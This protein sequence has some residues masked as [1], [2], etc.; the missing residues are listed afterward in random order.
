VAF[1]P[2]GRQ[3]ATGGDD[4]VTRLWQVATSR[5]RVALR[6]HQG[7]VAAVAFA[8]SGRLLLTAG[9]DG[10]ARL[11]N[12]GPL[13]HAL[14]PAV[15]R[16]T[17]SR[18]LDFRPGG[19]VLRSVE[20]IPGLIREWDLAMGLE[21]RVV[22]IGECTQVAFS[23]DGET[24]AAT[25]K[26]G[27][28]RLHRMEDGRETAVLHGHRGTVHDAA[29]RGDGRRLVTVGQDAT[30]RLWDVPSGRERAVLRGHVGE[31][32]A[33][34]FRPDGRVVATGG[35]DGTLRFWDAETGRALA[36]WQAADGWILGLAFSPDG[37]TLAAAG[38]DP[39]VRLWDVSTAPFRERHAL[40]GHRAPLWAL[41]FGPDGQ[42][43]ASG[44]IE[45]LLRL[46]D[47]TTYREL[48]A[49]RMNPAH[50]ANLY[51]VAFHPDGHLLAAGGSSG[52]TRSMISLFDGSR[53]DEA[54]R[55][56]REALGLIG[57]W[58]GRVDSEAELRDR[59]ARNPTIT[60]RVRAL[61]LAQVGPSWQ[62]LG[63]RLGDE[64]VGPLFREGLLREEVLARLEAA[65]DLDL[66]ARGPAVRLAA[67][68]PEDPAALNNASWSIVAR[69]DASADAYRLALRR[70]ERACQL[71]P[72]DGFLL[73]TLGVA[74]YRNALEHEALA[75]LEH[76]NARNGGREPA[77]LAFLALCRF[78]LGRLD[79]ARATLAVLREAIAARQ[80]PEDR[81]FLREVE[82][83]GFDAVFP[84][85]P[86]AH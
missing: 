12:A 9:L 41:A 23:R 27:L 10:T 39:I 36:D 71:R 53:V 55:E 14:V 46:W 38:T 52:F 42:R 85:N 13:Q 30:A 26:D 17:V 21:R 43:L 82:D 20:P 18:R 54:A 1:S 83:A 19:S 22:R 86:F 58:L 56:R 34:A 11:W 25:T 74:Q 76:S 75:T 3:L 65:P 50:G 60:G 7:A 45:G 49:W 73:N 78:R 67:A 44:D 28:T 29:F 77:D 69:R 16:R 5:E 81:A 66:P 70:I 33:A 63:E 24:L 59:V 8:D 68:W 31:V 35:R 84:A 32:S 64:L 15:G 57:F 61:A 4:G 6:G 47:L 80:T 48:A 40:R 37:R 51:C 62:S 72:D 2:D 79:G